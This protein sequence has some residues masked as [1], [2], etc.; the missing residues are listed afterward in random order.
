ITRTLLVSTVCAI[1]VLFFDNDINSW[2]LAT[3]LSILMVYTV[4]IAVRS[5]LTLWDSSEGLAY[6]IDGQ[7][8]DSA[9]MGVIGGP[10][11]KIYLR[12]V[13]V[14]T[15]SVACGYMFYRGGIM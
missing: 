13:F 10:R 1:I 8:A 6:G 4:W 11:G 15:K 14:A 5:L 2:L 9:M 7:R 3:A 12:L